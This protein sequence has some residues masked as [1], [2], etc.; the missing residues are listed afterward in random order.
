MSV[1]IGIDPGK[2]TGIAVYCRVTKQLIHLTTTTFCG[3]YG[4]ILNNYPDPDKV[5]KLVVEV[6][7]TKHAWILDS[8]LKRL[9][10]QDKAKFISGIKIALKISHDVGRVC[11][12]SELLSELLELAGYNVIRQHSTGDGKKLNRAQFKAIT[13]WPLMTNPHTRDAGMMAW[14]L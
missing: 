14:R 9:L 5:H 4:Y 6:P 13:G 8:R 12:E 10:Y 3:A 11:R 2:D 7:N 1:S